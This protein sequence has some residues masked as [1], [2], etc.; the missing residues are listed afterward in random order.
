MVWFLLLL[1]APLAAADNWTY[2]RSGPLY[3]HTN[4]GDGSAR[5]VLATF[6]QLRYWTAKTLGREELNPLWPVRLVIVKSD[7]NTASYRT[8]HLLLKRDGYVGGMTSR[9][10]IPPAWLE[11]FA[12]I[13]LRDDT[14]SLPTSI[15]NGLLILLSTFQAEA[16]R[17]T[18]GTPPPQPQRTRDWA[19]V[20]FLTVDPMYA[21][22]SRVFFSNLNQGADFDIAYRNA[23]EKTGQQMETEIDHYFRAGQFTVQPVSGKPLNPERDYRERPL[24]IARAQVLLADLLEG[25]AAATAYRAV[26]HQHGPNAGAFEGVGMWKEAIEQKSESA[27]AWLGFAIAEKDFTKAQPALRR[28]MELN[29]RWSE[30]HF[31]WGQRESAPNRQVPPIK[32]ATELEPRNID[33]W[34]ALAEA[35]TAAMDFAAAS[36]SWRQAERAGP[37][38]KTRASLDQRRRDFEQRRIDLEASERRRVEEEKRQEIEKLKNEALVSIRA[39]EAKANAAAGPVDLSQ[40]VV[41]WWDGPKPGGALQG[42][43]EQVDCLR[44]PARLL[45]RTPNGKRAQLLVVDPSKVAIL[46]AGH[47]SFT[48][49]PQKPPRRVKI[50]YQPKTDAKSGTSGEVMTIEFPQ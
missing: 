13:L 26:V 16:T 41:D 33:Y 47:Q 20:H 17:I 38:E 36:L 3:V 8:P 19:R 10:A 1:A 49:G 15:E 2:F 48:C 11:D 40:K 24:E 35:Q 39:A 31:H 32:R 29:P 7:R 28:A 46:G 12:R 34:I 6:D 45:V 4:A 14:R 25:P 50:E 22:R 37:D 21:G 44:G 23:F 43:L 9:D 18:L 30:P 5:K 42:L 27:R